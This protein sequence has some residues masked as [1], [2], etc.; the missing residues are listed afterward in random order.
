[1]VPATMHDT[2]RFD[3]G[4]TPAGERQL[5]AVKPVPE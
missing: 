1:M 4:L 3:G 2:R 5:S